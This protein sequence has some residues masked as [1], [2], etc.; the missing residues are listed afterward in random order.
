[1]RTRMSHKLCPRDILSRCRALIVFVVC[2]CAAYASYWAIFSPQ[3]AWNL[4][5]MFQ[6]L[7]INMHTVV[8]SSLAWVC[9]QYAASSKVDTGLYISSYYNHNDSRTV[10]VLDH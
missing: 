3:R 4:A 9:Q 7:L 5:P 6:H 2:T 10:A 8:F 1:M